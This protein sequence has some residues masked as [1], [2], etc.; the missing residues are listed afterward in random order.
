MRLSG[1]RLDTALAWTL[2]LVSQ[3][4]L[5]CWVCAQ[6]PEAAKKFGETSEKRG[7]FF[8]NPSFEKPVMGEDSWRVDRDRGT[9]ARFTVDNTDAA[10]GERS[11]RVTIGQVQGWGTQFGQ[12]VN[13]GQIGKTYTFAVMAKAAK[14]P[15]A[16]NLQI[17]RRAKPYD[18]ATAGEKVI[19]GR[20]WTEM[21]VTFKLEKN[22]SQGWFAY[23]ECTQ[24][25]YVDYFFVQVRLCSTKSAIR[26]CLHGSVTKNWNCCSASYG[27]TPYFVVGED[28]AG[29]TSKWRRHSTWC[30]TTFV[31]FRPRRGHA[32][33]VASAL[34]DD[35]IGN[36]K[37][38]DR[39]KDCRW[40]T[41]R[42]DVSCAS[43]PTFGSEA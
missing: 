19:L 43:G 39:T 37:G 11:A 26:R 24:P 35:R 7:N 30:S 15:V 1:V 5:P 14:E 20:D 34:A 36:A 31:R 4:L 6:V 22:F 27:Y 23:I 28:P 41:G 13:G 17:E 25:D 29:C 32:Q 10:D 38:L 8:T 2:T 21:H 42:R 3:G 12:G 16:V 40:A 9:V 33:L 18:R